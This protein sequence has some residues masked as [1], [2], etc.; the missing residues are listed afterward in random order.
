MG[1]KKIWN[2]EKYDDWSGL[3]MEPAFV[4]L[5]LIVSRGLK[6]VEKTDLGAL[7]SVSPHLSE[8][9]SM[10][11]LRRGVADA[12]TRLDDER[13]SDALM[14]LLR[15][16]PESK[17]LQKD[18]A[19]RLARVKFGE[20]D[21]QVEALE[22]RIKATPTVYQLIE[23]VS[24]DNGNFCKRPTHDRGP[25]DYFLLLRELYEELMPDSGHGSDVPSSHAR[26]EAASVLTHDAKSRGD[27]H[28]F[29]E[30]PIRSPSEADIDA[31]GR[32]AGQHYGTQLAL[33][34]LAK[35]LLTEHDAIESLNMSVELIDNDS[36][37][38]FFN[39]VREFHAR[40]TRYTAAVVL[41][42]DTR[43]AVMRCIPELKDVIWLPSETSDLDATVD[44]MIDEGLLEISDGASKDGY[45]SAA[46]R[47]LG[48]D[49]EY[50]K[51]LKGDKSVDPATYR[52]L[53]VEIADEAA[54]VNYRSTLHM[55]LT[56]SR[57]RCAWFADGPTFIHKITIDLTG[58]TDAANSKHTN[59]F[60]F[61]PYADSYSK[62]DEFGSKRFERTVDDWILRHHGFVI[63]W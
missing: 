36:K 3:L 54:L 29:P 7:L 38:Y 24:G 11:S 27:P 13:V 48:G 60:F 23:L 8:A 10:S 57:R 26:D 45:S 32:I 21:S 2:D 16:K 43:A 31:V 47:R 61:L 63:H 62:E 9:G 37:W 6:R 17:Q 53:E 1:R 28:A 19:I 5:Q 39:V 40:F 51:R 22:Q 58:F 49:H 52:L 15:A 55:R 56:R 46:F 25:G 30:W 4:A 18:Q 44:E 42:D 41:G 33:A 59:V 20:V 12:I 50:V 14:A 34:R 35:L